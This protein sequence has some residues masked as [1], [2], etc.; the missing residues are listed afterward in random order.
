MY[1]LVHKKDTMK[2]G[3]SDKV[4]CELTGELDIEYRNKDGIKHG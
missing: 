4:T 1:N 2:M 3:N